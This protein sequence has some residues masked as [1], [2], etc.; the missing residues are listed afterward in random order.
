MRRV[1]R[2]ELGQ[3]AT[4]ADRRRQVALAIVVVD[5]HLVV[6]ARV[7]VEALERVELG[8]LAVD[9]ELAGIEAMD[10]L[11]D[12]DRLDVE[13]LLDEELGGLAVE[14][15]RLA[16]LV[17][18]RQQVADAVER[19]RI[20]RVRL[21]HPAVH[22]D[23]L[24]DLAARDQLLGRARRRLATEPHQATTPASGV[25]RGTTVRKVSRWI[26]LGP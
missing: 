5:Q 6:G 20:A 22:L 18:P 23:R 10:L 11:V 3:L 2:L 14:L 8:E 26:G 4:D 15:D 13:A 21:E 1:L 17:D 16:V 9:V 24:V 12:R 7:V 25:E 19:R